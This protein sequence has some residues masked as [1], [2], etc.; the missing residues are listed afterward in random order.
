MSKR[1]ITLFRIDIPEI[2][3]LSQEEQQRVLDWCWNSAPVQ[4][5]WK[6]YWSRPLQFSLIPIVPLA[7]YWVV[8]DR[9]M[10]PLFAIVI[11][12]ALVCSFSLRPY[13]KKRLV[14][15]VRECAASRLRE[16]AS[17]PEAERRA[18]ATAET[19][20]RIEEQTSPQEFKFSQHKGKIIAM[21]VCWVLIIVLMLL[22]R[23]MH[24]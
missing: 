22:Q 6:S 3:D 4:Q 17:M 9:G 13:Y 11:P 5:V 15:T 7:V 2:A 21:A 8:T 1:Q 12:L 19:P 20:S 16:L 18:L 24:Q 14:A 23:R 10:G